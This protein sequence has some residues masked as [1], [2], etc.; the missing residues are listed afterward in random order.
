MNMVDMKSLTFLPIV[1]GPPKAQAKASY[2]GLSAICRSFASMPRRHSSPRF[3]RSD[4]ANQGFT[5]TYDAG[6]KTTGPL[7]DA[8]LLGAPR[9][10]PKVL[11]Q[12]LD[13]FV[14]GQDRAKKILSVAVYNHYQRVQEAQRREE[15]EQ[16]LMQQQ[17]RREMSEGHPLEGKCHARGQQRFTHGCC[18]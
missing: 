2:L 17:L 14:V 16:E 6:E 11:K 1:N 8:S 4:F 12:H 9:L 15:E 13:S 7:G 3:H 18:R 10:T 5:G